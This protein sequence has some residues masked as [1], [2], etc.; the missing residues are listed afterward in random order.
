MD[1]TV[2]P[3]NNDPTNKPIGWT[4]HEITGIAIYNAY[5]I[6]PWYKKIFYKRFWT[7]LIR[8]TTYCK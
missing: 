8:K 5:P 3:N 4:V 2:L 6:L 1:I 7:D